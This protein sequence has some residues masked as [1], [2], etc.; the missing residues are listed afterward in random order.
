M[1]TR[2][3][4]SP[5]TAVDHPV[6][7]F[8]TDF[9]LDGAAAICRGVMLSIARD[10][11]II[12]IQER[13]RSIRQRASLQ[14]DMQLSGLFA[15]LTEDERPNLRVMREVDPLIVFTCPP[16]D[17]LADHEQ[18]S[19][20]VRNAASITPPVAPKIRPAPE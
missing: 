13:L 11:Q 20:L 9:G 8:L 4:A 16:M 5:A 7:G 12:D 14:A 18:T 19:L 2:S 10:A 6:I 15:L 1:P 17:Y 3:P